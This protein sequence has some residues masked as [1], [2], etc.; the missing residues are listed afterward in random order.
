MNVLWD[1]TNASLADANVHDIHEIIKF[2]KYHIDK[3]GTNF[4][5]AIVANSKLEFGLSRVYEAYSDPLPF[6]K[7]VFYDMQEAIKWISD[8]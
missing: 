3:R 7:G 2:V 8:R 6:A 4:K 1:L 5:L